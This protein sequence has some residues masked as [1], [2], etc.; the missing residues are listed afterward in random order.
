MLGWDSFPPSVCGAGHWLDCECYRRWLDCDRLDCDRRQWI[1]PWYLVGYHKFK[2]K[3][4]YKYFLTANLLCPFISIQSWHLVIWPA[5]YQYLH[6]PM[7]EDL[8]EVQRL[9][10]QFQF[11]SHAVTYDLEDDRL[12]VLFDTAHKGILIGAWHLR[13]S[14]NIQILKHNTIN[15]YNDE[16]IV[17][18]LSSREH[19]ART[20]SLWLLRSLSPISNCIDSDITVIGNEP[21]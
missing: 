21:T 9:A 7:N 10:V 8:F 17:R 20:M 11:W 1:N 3:S 13:V 2:P 5:L 6:S 4:Q 15:I 12:W 16:K 18:N 19:I 14:P